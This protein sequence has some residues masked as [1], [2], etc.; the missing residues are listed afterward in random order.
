M[1]G[2]C[3]TDEPCC[4]QRLF[5]EDG[6]NLPE[7]TLTLESRHRWQAFA[8]AGASTPE[9]SSLTVPPTTTITSQELT[10]TYANPVPSAFLSGAGSGSWDDLFLPAKGWY[11]GPSVTLWAVSGDPVWTGSKTPITGKYFFHNCRLGVW[12]DSDT[13]VATDTPGVSPAP[14]W[15]NYI[16]KRRV[17]YVGTGSNVDYNYTNAG[18]PGL[19][20]IA[21]PQY[22]LRADGTYA[23]FG[24]TLRGFIIKD[25]ASIICRPLITELIAPHQCNSIYQNPCSSSIPAAGRY[26]APMRIAE[27]FASNANSE[28]NPLN[29]NMGSVSSTP[30]SAVLALESTHYVEEQFHMLFTLTEPSE[31]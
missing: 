11:L 14:E 23:S 28:L 17:E 22:A 16:A 10:L 25:F 31:S 24:G 8:L 29:T 15:Q 1:I 3:C 6:K 30:P 12:L 13:T 19:S 18:Q 9:C 4:A 2:C 21:A 27:T 26:L 20:T 5:R 7:L